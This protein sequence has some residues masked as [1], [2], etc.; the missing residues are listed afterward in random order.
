[1]NYLKKLPERKKDPETC[2]GSVKEGKKY[3]NPVS[4]FFFFFFFFFFIYNNYLFIY[5][6][7]LI[8]YK[9]KVNK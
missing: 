7:N 4:F 5:Y 2:C 3:I 8:N 6:I 9:L 1:M